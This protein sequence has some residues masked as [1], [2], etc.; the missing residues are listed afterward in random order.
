MNGITDILYCL[1]LLVADGIVGE[2]IVVDSDERVLRVT[3]VIV[4]AH[5]VFDYLEPF[6]RTV[7]VLREKLVEV[8]CAAYVVLRF[9]I[10]C[11]NPVRLEGDVGCAFA[12]AVAV[13]GF[14]PAGVALEFWMRFRI[15]IFRISVFDVAP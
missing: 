3:V 10:L 11:R 8:S 13:E 14:V 6:L 4:V 7:I 1:N 5:H 15:L 9:H 2:H 12:R